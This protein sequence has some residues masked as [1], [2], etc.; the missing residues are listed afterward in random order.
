VVQNVESD[1]AN[2]QVLVLHCGIVHQVYINEK[3]YRMSIAKLC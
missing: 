2:Q 3:R 1:Q